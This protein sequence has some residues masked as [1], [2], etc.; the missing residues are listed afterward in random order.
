M[1]VNDLS[2]EE[3]LAA[4]GRDQSPGEVAESDRAGNDADGV[5]KASPLRRFP[6]PSGVSK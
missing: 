5:Q 2:D 3:L 1:G 6:H 4:A